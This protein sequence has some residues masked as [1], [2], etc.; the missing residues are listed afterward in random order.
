MIKDAPAPQHIV[1]PLGLPL[2]RES[3]PAPNVPRWNARRKAELLFAIRGQLLSAQEAAVR[4]ALSPEEIARWRELFD[5]FG[6]DGL[7]ASKARPSRSRCTLGGERY[8]R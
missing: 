7:K 2:T 3:L 6:L 8:G 1:G 4:Y 5:G